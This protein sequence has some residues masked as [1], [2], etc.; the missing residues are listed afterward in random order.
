MTKLLTVIA[1]IV[2]VVG[3]TF[4]PAQQEETTYARVKPDQILSV[5]MHHLAKKQAARHRH[6]AV[7]RQLVRKPVEIKKKVVKKP[8]QKIYTHK[9]STPIRHKVSLSGI[10]ACIAKYESGGNPRAENPNS[11]ASGLFQFIDGTWNHF[12][13]YS[14]AKYAPVSVQL[15]KFYQV[16]DNGRGAG[17]WVV[18]Y[19][20]GY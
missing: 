11:S 13:G 16:W 17:H 1:M 8:S 19:K 20:C 14:R 9:R 3:L 5:N 12:G 2:G 7:S 18:A 15:E 6:L 4:V 10:A